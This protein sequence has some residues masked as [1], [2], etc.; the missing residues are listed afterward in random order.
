MLHTQMVAVFPP[1]FLWSFYSEMKLWMYYFY[2]AF[3]LLICGREML[4]TQNTL[5]KTKCDCGV[6]CVC[7]ISG[8]QTRSKKHFFYAAWYG[9]CDSDFYLFIIFLLICSVIL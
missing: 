9:N 1:S 4:N 7:I 8:G 2:A 6:F 5:K 3:L